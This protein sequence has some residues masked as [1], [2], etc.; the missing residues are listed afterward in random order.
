MNGNDWPPTSS[1]VWRHRCGGELRHVLMPMVDILVIEHV[2]KHYSFTYDLIF[3]IYSLT[4]ISRIVNFWPH[5]SL[6]PCWA[7][8]FCFIDMNVCIS[9]VKIPLYWYIKKLIPYLHLFFLP[10]FFKSLVYFLLS[11]GLVTKFWK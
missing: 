7:F 5:V 9:Y 11:M 2:L 4:V 10:C 1:G 8:S 3:S 6:Y